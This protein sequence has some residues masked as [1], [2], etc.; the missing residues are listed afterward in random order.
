M[1]GSVIKKLKA[2]F[3]LIG[4]LVLS[5]LVEARERAIAIEAR[6]FGIQGKKTT[7]REIKESNLDIILTKTFQIFL[8]LSIIWRVLLWIP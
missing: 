7:L 1:E 5:S 8:L 2:F 6:G 4:P 3:A